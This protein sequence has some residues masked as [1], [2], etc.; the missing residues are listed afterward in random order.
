MSNDKLDIAK[1]EL[2]MTQSQMDKYD[3]VSSKIKTWAIT[4]WGVLLGWSFQSK[5]KG[6]LILSLF[7]IIFFWIFDTINKNYREDYKKRR[8]KVSESIRTYIET[9]NWPDKFSTPNL[10]T[11]RIINCL[12]ILFQPHILLVYLSLAIASF[13]IL[14]I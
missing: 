6:I 3:D 2:Q 4:L 13:C 11:H 1:M 10:P 7:V 5:N 8:D 14:F 12:K 9:N